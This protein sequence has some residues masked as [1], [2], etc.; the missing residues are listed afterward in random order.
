MRIAIFPLSIA[1]IDDAKV[2]TNDRSNRFGSRRTWA[3]RCPCKQL[4]LLL[5]Q[6][7]SEEQLTYGEVYS[8]SNDHNQQ[9]L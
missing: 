5:D 8:L 3:I 4:L 7:F 2:Q 9:E 6:Y 1:R